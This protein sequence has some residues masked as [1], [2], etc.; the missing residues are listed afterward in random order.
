MTVPPKYDYWK[1]T[2]KMAALKLEQN[3]ENLNKFGE[4]KNKKV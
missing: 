2:L 3:K 1:K 4:R